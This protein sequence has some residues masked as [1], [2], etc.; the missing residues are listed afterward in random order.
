MAQVR[1]SKK[2]RAWWLNR[3]A[4]YRR[5]GLYEIA[6]RSLGYCNPEAAKKLIGA[7]T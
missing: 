6:R 7:K 3:A 1:M 2:D 4:H 5:L